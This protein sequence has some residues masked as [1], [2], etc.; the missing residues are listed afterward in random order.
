[1]TW[2]HKQAHIFHEVKPRTN[3]SVK[4]KGNDIDGATV[5]T[6]APLTGAW[7]VHGESSA[8]ATMI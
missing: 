6:K 7:Q 4:S 8:S 1:M 5:L 2:N 3:T